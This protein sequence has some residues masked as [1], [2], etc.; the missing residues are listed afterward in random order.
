MTSNLPR[1][2]AFSDR[3]KREIK[4]LRK[5]YRSIQADIQPLIKQLEQGE[6]PGDQVP[7]VG[8]PV[9]KVRVRSSDIPKGKSGGYRVLYYV[10]TTNLLVLITIYVKSDQA[11]ISRDTVRRIVDE[12]DLPDDM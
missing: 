4:T 3:F 5:R 8:Y 12:L 9:Y 6:T 1:R 7:G 11:D 2:V 10:R